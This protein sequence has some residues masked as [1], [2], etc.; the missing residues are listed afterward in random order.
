VCVCFVCVCVCMRVYLKTTLYICIYIY[1]SIV[2]VMFFYMSTSAFVFY[3]KCIK[4]KY[5]IYYK[6]LILQQLY[7][8]FY[9][10]NK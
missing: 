5:K 9:I 7:R 2:Y 3:V 10:R 6:L 8:N 1:K 4:I